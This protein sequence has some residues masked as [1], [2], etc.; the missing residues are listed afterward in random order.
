MQATDIKP[1]IFN[2]FGSYFTEND[3]YKENDP[4]NENRGILQRWQELLA[5]END[6]FLVTKLNNFLIDVCDYHTLQT[7]FIPLRELESGLTE[8]LYDSIA[9]RIWLMPYIT[10]IHSNR[11][12]LQ[13]YIFLLGRLGFNVQVN[14]SY[15]KGSLDSGTFD[16]GTLDTFSDNGA[17]YELVLI[18]RF[19][20]P[21]TPEIEAQVQRIITYNNPIHARITDVKYLGFGGGFS[22]GFSNGFFV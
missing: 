7:D 16:S 8:P 9:D 18:N 1:K 10:R 13:N 2:F 21:I 14:E 4:E 19:D 6:N 5:Q 15:V 17:S 3:T 12:T 22:N 11:G 20:F